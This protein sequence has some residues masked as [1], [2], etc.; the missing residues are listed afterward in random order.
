MHQYKISTCHPLQT[1]MA[2]V[3]GARARAPADLPGDRGPLDLHLGR[4][5]LDGP[6]VT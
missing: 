2:A 5:H 6:A 3:P 1:A 4:R